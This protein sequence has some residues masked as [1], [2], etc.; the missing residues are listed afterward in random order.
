MKLWTIIFTAVIAGLLVV[1][2]AFLAVRHNVQKWQPEEVKAYESTARAIVAYNLSPSD[3]SAGGVF[4]ALRLAWHTLDEAPLGADDSRLQGI[5]AEAAKI[6][7]DV[8][9]QRGL[10]LVTQHEV[11]AGR[12]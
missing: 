4:L 5:C 12:M 2:G 3:E 8:R 9:R 1:A 7:N 6:V 10:P 11:L